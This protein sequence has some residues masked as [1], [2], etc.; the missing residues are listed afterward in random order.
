MTGIAKQKG[1]PVVATGGTS[2]HVHLLIALPPM[3]ALAK[4]IQDI[5]GNSSRWL[6]E[7]K[8]GFAWQKG[9]AAFGVSESRREAVIVYL[10]G[11]EEHH[12][13]WSFEQEFLTLLKKS[14]IS[15]DPEFVFG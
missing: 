5:K 4:A 7:Q 8:R 12:R 9:Y 6:N 10:L 14:R 15:Y 3:I 11:Q 13:K 1:I 2:N